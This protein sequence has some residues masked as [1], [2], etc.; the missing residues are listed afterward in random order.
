MLTRNHRNRPEANAEI[1]IIVNEFLRRIFVYFGNDHRHLDLMVLCTHQDFADR[2]VK[3]HSLERAGYCLGIGRARLLH[4]LGEHQ[5][6][7]ASVVGIPGLAGLLAEQGGERRGVGR[8]V[9]VLVRLRDL[10][11]VH[12]QARIFAIAGRAAACPP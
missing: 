6:H 9:H 1:N 7:Q 10:L 12:G 11:K 4:R 8:L 3:S 2:T 5:E